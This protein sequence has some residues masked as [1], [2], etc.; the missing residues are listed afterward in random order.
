M[1]SAKATRGA[2]KGKRPI[3]SSSSNPK[4]TKFRSQYN[5]L[6]VIARGGPSKKTLSKDALKKAAKNALDRQKVL[7]GLAGLEGPAHDEMVETTMEGEK[8]KNKKKKKKGRKSDDMET[9]SIASAG[10]RLTTASFASVWSNCSNASLN[11]FFNTWDPKLET[12]KDALAVIAGLSQIMSS[13][14]LEQSDMQFVKTLF[15]ILSS[16]ET[17]A[18]VTTG[19]LLA[20]TFVMRKLPASMIMENFDSFY[21]ILQQLMEKYH[22]KKKKTLLKSLIRCFACLSKAHPKGK[23]AIESSLRKKINISIRQCKVQDKVRL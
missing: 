4:T 14:G 3:S 15:E 8:T 5:S 9:D 20:L 19:A 21:N 22:E 16:P 13:K 7:E 6:A 11:E 17:P 2:M 1:A 12:H 23:G 18:N 10:T